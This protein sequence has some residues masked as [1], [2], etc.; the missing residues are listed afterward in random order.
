MTTHEV[1]RRSRVPKEPV[2]PKIPTALADAKTPDNDLSDDGVYLSMQYES[3]DLS[4]GR[5]E[6]VEFERCRFRETSFSAT[7]LRR[8]NLTDVEFIGCDLANL[9]LSDSRIFSAFVD[10]SRM[11]GT[12]MT[13]CG[14]RDVLFSG[15]RA[16]LSSFRFARFKNVVFRNCNLTEANFQGADL[17]GARF[18]GCKLV[19][20]QFSNAKMQ[21]ARLSD[22]D[23]WGVAGIQSFQGAIVAAADAQSLV[24]ALA[25]A[26]GITI[27]D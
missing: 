6:D 27:E 10:R 23:L 7:I 16:D 20:S 8:A 22:C 2:A 1:V 17:T 11:T 4:G 26:L 18:E 9:R 21:G 5:A 24:L 19:G 3:L 14:F 12:A 15:C 13:D 25:S